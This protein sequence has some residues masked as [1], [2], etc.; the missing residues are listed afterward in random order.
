M[1]DYLSRVHDIPMCN[2]YDNI[3]MQSLKSTLY[4]KDVIMTAKLS[5]N[6]DKRVEC[7]KQLFQNF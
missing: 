1:L 2:K 5:K 4:P 3:R 7:K 6:L